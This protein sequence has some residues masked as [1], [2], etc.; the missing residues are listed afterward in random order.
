MADQWEAF[1]ED[2]TSF[3]QLTGSRE[4]AATTDV[5]EATLLK[6]E[7]YLRVLT[8]IR[9]RLLTAEDD[10]DLDDVRKGILDLLK[11]LLEIKSRWEDIE[12][13]VSVSGRLA[14]ER[15]YSGERGRPRVFI[16]KEQV[17]LL[18]EL[19]LSW[20]Q[21]ASLFGISRRTLYR[22]RSEYGMVDPY[23]FSDISDRDLQARIASI[24]QVMPDA[25]QNMV[26][27]MLRAQGIHV[28]LP[29]IRESIS[30]VD[31]VATALRWASPISRRV[32][33]VPRPNALWHMDGNHK[34][35]RYASLMINRS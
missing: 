21:I 13:G 15:I 32:Y 29:R 3:L 27:G 24:K 18:R 4:Q 22:I 35:V 30:R 11:S 19:R 9:E 25:G 34:L 8:A 6:V 5:A 16:R 20:T 12:C 31:P 33:A 23:D 7:N 28:S 26:K 1:F 10:R 14:H 2:L 17:E